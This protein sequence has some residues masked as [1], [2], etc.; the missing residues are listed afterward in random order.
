[1]DLRAEAQPNLHPLVVVVLCARRGLKRHPS[2]SYILRRF[3]N[4]S[5]ATLFSR[6]SFFFASF[7]FYSSATE[8]FD[9]PAV[10]AYGWRKKDEMKKKEQK[11]KGI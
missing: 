11:Q 2:L 6:A 9:N 10:P 7:L 8:R 4:A 5:L 3:S 1:L